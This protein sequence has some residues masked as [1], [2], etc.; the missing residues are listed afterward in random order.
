MNSKKGKTK[1]KKK[2]QPPQIPVFVKKAPEILA[3]EWKLCLVMK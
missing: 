2:Q 1:G 3:E